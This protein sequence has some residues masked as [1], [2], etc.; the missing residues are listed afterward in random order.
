M[1][2]RK[3]LD[4]IHKIF[5]DAA[6]EPDVFI[7]RQNCIQ[8]GLSVEVYDAHMDRLRKN[9]ESFMDAQRMEMRKVRDFES[10]FLE[11]SIRYNTYGGVLGL[12]PRCPG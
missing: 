9:V 5:D 11:G 12:T 10:E 2:T 7:T 3:H 6:Q 1:L 8:Y 4:D